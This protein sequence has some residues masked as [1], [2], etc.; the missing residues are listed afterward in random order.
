[1]TKKNKP[2]DPLTDLL[3]GVQPEILIN[4]ITAIAQNRPDVRNACFDYLKTHV[5][6]SPEQQTRS[7][8]EI[9]MALWAELSPDL[10]ELDSYGGRDYGKANHVATLLYDIQK[11]L[12]G[13]KVDKKIR[14][15]VLEKVLPF[16]VSGNAGLD[17]ALYD[18]AYATC[19]SD[20]NLRG[21]AQAFEAMNSDWPRD[22]ARRIYRKLG[23]REKYLELRHQ[24]LVYGGDY[25][26]LATFYWDEGNRSKALSVA[27]EGMNKG[28]GRMDELRLFL[29]DRA[30][31][32]GNREQYLALQFEQATDR[33]TLAKYNEFRKICTTEEWN[34]Y[35]NKLLETLDRTGI[36]ERLNILMHRK[37]YEKALAE[38]LKEKNAYLDSSVLMRTAELLESRFPDSILTYYLSRFNRL[39]SETARKGYIA[40][41]QVMLK[42]RRILVDI[43]KD[44]N[45]WMKFA[46]KIKAENLRRPAFQEEFARIVPGW[47]ELGKE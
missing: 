44:E 40:R 36:S 29:A 8:G 23:D 20:E 26:D 33:L 47:R 37:E 25:H 30:R 38:L 10:E 32:S 16:I 9:V 35:E 18:L 24:K 15:E 1:M 27:E 46:E 19:Y 21:L 3:A 43:L 11:K 2:P 39:K 17:D 22:H 4:L 14:R 31:K 6:L 28:Q 12:N 34:S 13:R 7:E 5:K 45:R 42:I 41:A